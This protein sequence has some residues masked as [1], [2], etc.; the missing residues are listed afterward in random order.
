MGRWSYGAMEA[1]PRAPLGWILPNPAEKGAELSFGFYVLSADLG[2]AFRGQTCDTIQ[3][4]P[5]T[6]GKLRAVFPLGIPR[7]WVWSPSRSRPWPLLFLHWSCPPLLFSLRLSL[8]FSPASFCF[9]LSIFPLLVHFHPSRHM[10]TPDHPGTSGSISCD[11]IPLLWPHPFPLDARVSRPK[12]HKSS[13][14]A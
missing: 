8:L 11:W 7:G 4:I 14:E 6:A 2:S 10:E 3:S 13:G 1:A 5:L 12:L 9:S